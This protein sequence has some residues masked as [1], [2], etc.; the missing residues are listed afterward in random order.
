MSSLTD[1]CRLVNTNLGN[2]ATTVVVVV[3]DGITLSSSWNQATLLVKKFG[4]QNF[5]H[6]ISEV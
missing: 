2:P 3:V 4:R 6:F 1:S 5:R